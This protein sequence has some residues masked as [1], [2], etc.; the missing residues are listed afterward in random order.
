MNLSP[1]TRFA[2]ALALG[3]TFSAPTFAQE[4]AVDVAE[5]TDDAVAEAEPVAE[6]VPEADLK[7]VLA[8][9]PTTPAPNPAVADPSLLPVYKDFGELPGITAL[10]EDFMVRL[11]ADPR[12]KPFFENVDQVAVKKHLVEQF[13]VILGGPCSYTGRDMREAHAGLEINRSNFNALVE[14]LQVAMD[15]RGIPFRS[16]NRLLAKLAPMHREIETR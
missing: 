7:A 10:M 13:C 1:G 12:T 5:A 6:P 2:L 3:L 4:A 11:L 14:D 16:Q 9:Q 15:K 8:R